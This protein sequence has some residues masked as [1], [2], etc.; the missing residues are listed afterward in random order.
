MAKNFRARIRKRAGLTQMKLARLTG[1]SQA[2]ISAWEADDAELNR[3]GVARIANAIRKHLECAP[4][5]ETVS[6]IIEALT[7]NLQGIGL[8][9]RS[10]DSGQTSKH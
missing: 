6:D 1:I 9:S 5:F 7:P 4:Q 8:E 10:R 3:E 2:R